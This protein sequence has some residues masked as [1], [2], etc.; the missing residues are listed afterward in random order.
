MAFEILLPHIDIIEK[1]LKDG[2]SPRAIANEIGEPGLYSTIRRY[3]IA[4]F[5]INK[6]AN[7]AWRQERAKNYDQR[8][9]EGKA[10]I[11]DSLEVIN[12]GKLRAKQLLSLE[13]G[14]EY[15]TAE[16]E[17]R[18]LSIGSASIHW[19]AGQRMICDLVR[20]EAEIA[21]D[22]PESRKANAIEGLH[23]SDLR[24]IL[25]ALDATS[26]GESEE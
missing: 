19:Q 16:G 15:E 21:G 10:A 11:V 17:P 2:K 6:E 4:V 1:G 23:E 5:D 12:L 20:T 24:A 14:Q 18:T 13:L 22:D 8:L 7:F 3:K 26:K 9:E 25:E